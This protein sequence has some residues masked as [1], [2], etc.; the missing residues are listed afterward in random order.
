MLSGVA[1]NVAFV[2]II[3]V[4][5]IVSG[6][7]AR[8]A[9]GAA[10]TAAAVLVACVA[11]IAVRRPAVRERLTHVAVWTLNRPSA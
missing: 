3:S 6:N 10:G 7:I 2:L 9:A 5:G 8:I 4:G 11:M 1:S